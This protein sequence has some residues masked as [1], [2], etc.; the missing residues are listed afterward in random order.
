MTG[1]VVALPPLPGLG[2]VGVCASAC[3]APRSP[4]SSLICARTH[5]LPTHVG[6]PPCPAP[7]LSPP[8]AAP[9][10]TWATRRTPPPV[11]FAMRLAAVKGGREGSRPGHTR[12]EGGGCA[13]GVCVTLGCLSLM[14]CDPGR[15]PVMRLLRCPGIGAAW[16]FLRE[17]TCRRRAGGDR[18]C[19][20]CA[21]WECVSGPLH[22]LVTEVPSYLLC[23]R[24]CGGSGPAVSLVGVTPFP[25]VLQLGC[26]SCCGRWGGVVWGLE[27]HAV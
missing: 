11:T 14:H 2:W 8:A 13:S 9:P 24:G 10:P 26:G 16:V 3:T 27:P 15:V 23:G 17:G 21:C 7:L 1:R 19:R 20:V 6:A 12:E 5:P 4:S 18:A 25:C 22:L